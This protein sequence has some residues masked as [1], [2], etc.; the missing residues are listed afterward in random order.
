MPTPVEETLLS[1]LRD[2]DG[3]R[4]LAE[5]R[6]ALPSLDPEELGSRWRAL[7]R[8]GRMRKGQARGAWLLDRDHADELPAIDHDRA[9]FG[10]LVFRCEHRGFERGQEFSFR[11]GV[12]LL[13][14]E[15]GSGKSSLIEV[16]RGLVSQRRH[17]REDAQ[18]VIHVTAAQRVPVLAFCFEKD[19]RRT[20]SYF[21]DDIGFQV[22]AM[23]SSHGETVNAMMDGFARQAD[24]SGRPSVWLLDE[25]DASLSIRSAHRLVATFAQ[26]ARAGHQIIASVHNPIVIASARE[27]LSLEHRR[28][29]PS[30]EFIDSHSLDSG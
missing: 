15:Q 7:G 1:Y 26:M 12:N 18:R 19:N 3:E 16:V 17:Q 5:A 24:E 10:S 4:T 29:M 20:L 2:A 30:T 13:V 6:K 27:V 28:W 11:P 8:S 9:L 25:P 22:A 14:G 23:K 21:E